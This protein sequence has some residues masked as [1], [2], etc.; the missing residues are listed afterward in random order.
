MEKNGS[1]CWDSKKL[2]LKKQFQILNESNV[3]WHK[4]LILEENVLQI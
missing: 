4:H 2:F 1:N 3:A